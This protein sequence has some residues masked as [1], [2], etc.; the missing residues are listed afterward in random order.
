MRK[1]SARSITSRNIAKRSAARDVPP[2]ICSGTFSM[3]GAWSAQEALDNY[4]HL[5]SLGIVGS[6][7]SIIT[8]SRSEWCDQARRFGEEVIAKLD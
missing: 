8:D 6:G 3:Q 1:S 4:A 2:V 7:A 5:R